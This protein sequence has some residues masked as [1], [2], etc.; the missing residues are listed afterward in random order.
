[1]KAL[2]KKEAGYDK[3][4]LVDLP[5]PEAT[6]D[7][8]QIKVAY[9]GICG[10]DLHTFKGE[11]ASSRPPLVLG[12]EFSG[13]VTAVGPD[14]KNIKVGDR[15]TSETTYS[16]CGTCPSCRDRE[17][18][19]CPTRKGLGTQQN[20]SMAEY[21]VNRE[22]SVHVVPENV[23]L[24]AAAVT[25]PLACGVHAVVEKAEVKEG[26]VVV[27]FGAGTIGQVV[28]QVAK[29]QGATVIMAGL[30]QDRERFETAVSWGIDRCVDQAAEDLAQI[31]NEYTD[32]WG[33]DVVIE[34]SGAV[35]ALAKAFEVVRRKGVVVQE[36]IF[37]KEETPVSCN[38]L[39]NKEIVYMGSRTQKPSAWVTS[40]ELMAAGK[41][42][43]EKLVT[44]VRPLAEWRE[45]FDA[46]A[47]GEGLKSVLACS[48]L[49]TEHL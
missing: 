13:V 7:L 28:A 3:M 27:V 34:C 41:V 47:H 16:T 45:S 5:T 36:G 25:E 8:V 30:P 2:M 1:M 43:V 22:E 12:H 32:N 37:A 35:P 14:V 20:G 6:G 39:M 15:V 9:S 17:Y 11:Y 31:V 48:D 40:L 38:V 26:D 42:D 23:S 4:E 44:S 24:L 33:A 46:L 18:N 29:A 10:T 19:I 49:A 21:V